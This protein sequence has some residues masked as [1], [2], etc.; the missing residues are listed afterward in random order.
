MI[1]AADSRLA[2]NFRSEPVSF[3]SEISQLITGT[4]GALA[5]FAHSERLISRRYCARFCST[6]P[7]PDVR[8]VSDLSSR[9]RLLRAYSLT[10]WTKSPRRKDQEA[11]PVASFDCVNN[12]LEFHECKISFTNGSLA[13]LL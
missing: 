10:S 6:A 8:K 12:V 7:P 4:A 13:K 9:S 1:Q 11:S 3:D 5:R 2:R